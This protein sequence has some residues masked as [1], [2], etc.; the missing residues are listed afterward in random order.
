MDQQ[1][2]TGGAA[3]GAPP[4][5]QSRATRPG[6]PQDDAARE[7]AAVDTPEASAAEDRTTAPGA[8]ASEARRTGDPAAPQDAPADRKADD[9]QDGQPDPARA[10][11]RRFRLF[12]FLA[13]LAIAVGGGLTAYYILYA[14]RFE[15]TDDAFID[16]EIVRVSSQVAGALVD[17]PA[18]EN[19][20]VAPGDVL[21]RIDPSAAEAQLALTEAQL[22]EARSAVGSASAEIGQAKANVTAQ[23]SARDGAKVR[24]D[25]AGTTAQRY[26]ELARRSGSTTI[27]QQQVDDAVANA[28][29]AEADLA[30]AEGLVTQARA[31][32]TSAGASLNSAQAQVS[33]AQAQV[34]NARVQLGYHTVSAAIPGQIVQLAVNTGSFVAAGTQM[35]AIVPD[36]LYVTA[37]FKETQLQDIS[38]GQK[39]DIR[40]DAFPDVEFHGHVDSIQHGAGQ[41][42]ALL[43]PQNATGNFVKV[44]QRVPVRIAID[45]PSLADYPIGPG[46]SVVPS[47]RIK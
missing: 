37:N 47:V 12:G 14:S 3:A 33:A 35:M 19:T 43:P 1:L 25:N 7:Q 31:A 32:V 23:E 21:A 26:E 28:R 42:F 39:V 15:V 8:G 27:S 38:V 46:M 4:G 18:Q 36:D 16:G 45:N 20:R 5:D 30:S 22:A 10:R 41:A 6:D 40:V 29:Q 17:V 44:V 2:R 24:A 13:L 11:K 34:E 9:G